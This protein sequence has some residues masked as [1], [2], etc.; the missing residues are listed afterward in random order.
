MSGINITGTIFRDILEVSDA[1]V[2]YRY[3]DMFY[4]EFAAVTKKEHNDGA[5]YYIGCGLDSDVFNNH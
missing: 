5:V 3:G 2:L 4:D 1:E